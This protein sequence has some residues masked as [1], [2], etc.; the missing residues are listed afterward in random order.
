MKKAENETLSLFNRICSGLL[1][2]L[3]FKIEKKQK[4]NSKK[5]KKIQK[6]KKIRNDN[7]FNQLGFYPKIFGIKR[8]YSNH[9]SKQKEC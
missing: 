9:K 1:F 2:S 3:A 8:I 6:F 7:S 4:K 5:F